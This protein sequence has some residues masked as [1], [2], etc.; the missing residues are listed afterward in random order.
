MSKKFTVTL[1]VS[2]IRKLQNDLKK[3]KSNLYAKAEQF[4][5][6]L[7]DE[8]VEIA[9]MKISTFDAMFTG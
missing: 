4:A 8:G 6:E 7:A 3:Y 1:S 5:R 9:K 2:S